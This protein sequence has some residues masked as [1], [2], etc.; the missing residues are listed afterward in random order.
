MSNQVIHAIKCNIYYPREYQGSPENSSFADDSS[1]ILSGVCKTIRT[2]HAI[3]RSFKVPLD[4]SGWKLQIFL[5]KSSSPPQAMCVTTIYEISSYAIIQT[6]NSN[7]L[8][9]LLRHERMGIVCGIEYTGNQSFFQ[10][11]DNNQAKYAAP[12]RNWESRRLIF[13]SEFLPA[14]LWV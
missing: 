4:N 8:N 7:T 13:S 9:T 6:S 5:T 12:N 1:I 14:R 2:T 11:R 10:R 3:P